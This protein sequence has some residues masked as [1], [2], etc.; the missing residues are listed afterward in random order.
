[1]IFL[2][3][4]ADYPNLKGGLSLAYI[5]TR[6]VYYKEQGVE[7][8]VLNFSADN[9]YEIDGIQVYSLSGYI[10][11]AVNKKYDLIL[12]HASNLRNHYRFLIKYGKNFSKIVFFYH[13]HE[14][15]KTNKV[16]PK[17]YDFIKRS[18]LRDKVQDFYDDIKCMVWRRY[19]EKHYKKLYHIFVSN[20][21]KNEFV[22]WVHPN[23]HCLANRSY[24]VYNSV[25]RLFEK[26]QYD[27]WKEKKYDFV[28]IRSMLDGSKYAIDIVNDIAKLNPQKKFLLVG[29]GSFFNYIQKADNLDWVDERISHQK[30]IE[31]LNSAK[32]ALM[33]TRTDAQGVMMC[34]MATFGMPLITSDI[35]VCH[36]VLDG[37]DG[38][39]F[40]SNENYKDCDF[41]VLYD[42]I[43]DV[44][45]KKDV[46]FY[47]KVGKQELEILKGIVT[48]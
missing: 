46:Y 23:S 3:L 9:N 6:C 32:C 48:V 37:W 16:Y 13:G 41:S 36:E 5:R 31:L 27:C 26:E 42:G 2:V 8:E 21:M 4:A 11:A 18:Y 29:K 38:V 33:P 24:I 7:V 35:P 10:E 25:G 14:V 34:E 47:S 17:P 19:I 39:A 28:T 45:E 22:R 1:M 43:K 30:M 12:S 15:L 44:A 20:W 40:I